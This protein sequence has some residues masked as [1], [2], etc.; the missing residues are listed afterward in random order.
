MLKPG[1]DR[2]EV[3][4][5]FFLV[6]FAA[7]Q[8]LGVPVVPENLMENFKDPGPGKDTPFEPSASKRS[9]PEFQPEIA[10]IWGHPLP[11]NPS[12]DELLTDLVAFT[13]AK[14]KLWQYN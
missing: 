3:R 14:W 13:D 8:R 10:P 12:Y 2:D 9:K 11:A 6:V 1:A 5:E 4:S 7:A